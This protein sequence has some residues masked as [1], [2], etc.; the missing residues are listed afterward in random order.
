[1]KSWTLF[2]AAGL[3]L[4]G[5]AAGRVSYSEPVNQ[6]GSGYSVSIKKDKDEVWRQ[7]IKALRKGSFAVTR[8]DQKSGLLVVSY[9]AD[10]EKFV[11]CGRITSSV[12]DG[13]GERTYDFPASRALQDYEVM[14]EGNL[15]F[16]NRKMKLDTR[17]Q[18]NI[19]DTGAKTTGVS[20]TARYILARTVVMRDTRGRSKTLD[21]AVSFS[22]GEE[23]SLP[24]SSGVR[25]RSNGQLE[26]SVLKLLGGS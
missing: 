24:G 6:K 15:F 9:G 13:K 23:G 1:M 19:Q 25:C 17:I 12:K 22:S 18:I 26:Q 5:C 21:D 2:L 11:D 16:V 8:Q 14:N 7:A 3:A 4:H 10:P 20:L